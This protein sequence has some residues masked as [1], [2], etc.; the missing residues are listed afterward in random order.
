MCT[1]LTHHDMRRSQQ[2]NTSELQRSI[3]VPV[4]TPPGRF[5]LM[6]IKS[7]RRLNVSKKRENLIVRGFSPGFIPSWR[8]TT[9]ADFGE[10][11]EVP[12]TPR[13][14]APQACEKNYR[15]FRH[16]SID[17]PRDRPRVHGCIRNDLV[18]SDE[19]HLAVLP[20]PVCH[21]A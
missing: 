20:V 21:F 18:P 9:R 13:M 17:L 19:I 15:I 10:S 3:S 6:S 1:H 11:I 8:L 5:F 7:T 4:S 12:A 14:P 2:E 16:T